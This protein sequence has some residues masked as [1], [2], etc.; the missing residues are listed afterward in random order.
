MLKTTQYCLSMHAVGMRRLLNGKG[1]RSQLIA[2]SVHL[3]R[4][5]GRGII[6][7][8]QS[9]LLSLGRSLADPPGF[10]PTLV[11]MSRSKLLAVS[12]SGQFVG[13][14]SS[15]LVVRFARSILWWLV[16]SSIVGMVV[17]NSALEVRRG[18]LELHHGIE[19][20]DRAQSV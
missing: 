17:A 19:H 8:R 18:L 12:R 16:A 2:G 7:I 10:Q 9:G 3:S 11:T 5:T 1:R 6:A 20:G 14:R 13:S 4:Y 15:P